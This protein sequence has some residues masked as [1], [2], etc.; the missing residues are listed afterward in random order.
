MAKPSETRLVLN[1]LGVLKPRQQKESI[2]V[3]K[4]CNVTK[5]CFATPTVSPSFGA[6]IDEKVFYFNGFPFWA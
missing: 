5:L 2:E 3:W 6:V 4:R 1:A